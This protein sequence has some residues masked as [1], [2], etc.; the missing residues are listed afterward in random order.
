MVQALIMEEENIQLAIVEE[1][2]LVLAISHFC[3]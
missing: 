3:I 1:K 2:K